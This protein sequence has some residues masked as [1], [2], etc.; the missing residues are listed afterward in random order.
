MGT[1]IAI[2][3]NLKAETEVRLV[4]THEDI[5]SKSQKFTKAWCEK[6]IKKGRMDHD[7]K[8]GLLDRMTYST[9]LDSLYDT[10]FVVEAI[11]ESFAAKE[12]TF[13][14]LA[15]ITP[16]DAILASNTSSI[17]ITKIAGA[18][19]E[20]AQNVIGMHFMNPVPVMKLVEIIPGLQTSTDTLEKTLNLAAQMGKVTTQAR[21]IPGF[22]ANRILIPYINEAIW[23]LYEGIG[24][25]HDIDTTMK[26]GTNVPM[27]PL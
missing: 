19:P 21:D 5:L 11:V 10:D 7:G 22:I 20:R 12:S 14:A 2:V 18:I 26:L 17:S 15:E 27:G 16:K 24:T 4:D 1:G 6:E 23:A 13:R 3:A 9:K 25:V 8:Y